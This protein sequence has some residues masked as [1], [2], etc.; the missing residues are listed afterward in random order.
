VLKA[1]EVTST[2]TSSS[3]K[4]A[5]ARPR[6]L[7]VAPADSRRLLP[8]KDPREVDVYQYFLAVAA[9][10]LAGEPF[11]SDFWLREIPQFCLHDQAIWHAVMALGSM[12]R[13]YKFE[14]HDPSARNAFALQQVNSSIKHL[15][16]PKPA[17]SSTDRWR[18]LVASLLFT[19][20]CIL[21]GAMDQGRMHFRYG[22]GIFLELEKQ[23]KERLNAVGGRSWRKPPPPPTPVSMASLRTLLLS[24]QLRDQSLLDMAEVGEAPSMVPEDDHFSFWRS[25][26][27]PEPPK[28]SESGLSG[29]YVIQGIRAA[30]SLMYGITSAPPSLEDQIMLYRSREL[31]LPS[32]ARAELPFVRRFKEIGKTLEMFQAALLSPSEKEGWSQRTRAQMHRATKYLELYHLANR[33][34][35]HKDPDEPNPVKR[36]MQLPAQCKKI[37]DIAEEVLEMERV[38]YGQGDGTY[39]MPC[40][41]V[42]N[43]ALATVIQ[44]GFGHETRMRAVAL[45]RKPRLEGLW[46]MLMTASIVEA[47]M[48]RE[49]EEAPKYWAQK[50]AEGAPY[51]PVVQGT[52]IEEIETG[53]HPMFRLFALAY[54]FKGGTTERRMELTIRLWQEFVDDKPGRRVQI[55]W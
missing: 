27:A 8:Y 5:A 51:K 48:L 41:G 20:V 4:L 42:L 36:L 43:P 22:Y 55:T 3:H 29:E 11:S 12:C 17:A 15:L 32:L 49:W 19:C 7:A 54:T 28:P 44:N 45:L 40:P 46:D 1:A 34:R 21:Q 18:A 2:S 6:P 13:D 53:A 31:Q 47:V 10:S 37:V 23:Y 33:L 26:T 25:Y 30:E 38:G 52:G 39:V 16:A 35:L 14:D 50:A 24:F 9:P